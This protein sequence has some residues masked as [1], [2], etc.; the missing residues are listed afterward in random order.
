MLMFFSFVKYACARF[1][2]ISENVKNVV[3]CFFVMSLIPGSVGGEIIKIFFA[4]DGISSTSVL[5][6]S[7]SKIFTQKL[8]SGEI[9]RYASSMRKMHRLFQTSK[10]AINLNLSAGISC[11][12]P[13]RKFFIKASIHSR[14]TFAEV[15]VRKYLPM[16]RLTS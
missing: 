1:K 3:L 9:F 6:I 8:K 4:L 13:M 10:L 5:R 15:I 14:S 12:L 16:S 11:L 2:R 7:Y